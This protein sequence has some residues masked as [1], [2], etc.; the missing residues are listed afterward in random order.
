MEKECEMVALKT[1][2]SRDDSDEVCTVVSHC[3]KAVAIMQ[4]PRW[5]GTRLCAFN[6]P[7][8]AVFV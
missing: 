2:S 1:L 5:K 3:S 7:K 4:V 8:Y 6:W